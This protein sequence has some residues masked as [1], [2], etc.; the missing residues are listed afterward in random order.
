MRFLL[1]LLLL[2]SC[3]FSGALAQV[4][5]RTE[6]KDFPL[7]RRTMP[8][9]K[10][11][12]KLR[13]GGANLSYRPDQIPQLAIR[14]PGGKRSLG[15]WLSFLLAD[16]ELTYEQNAAGYLIYP[17]P[18][19][20]TRMI[21]LYGVVT[22]AETG[23]R[24]I[25]AS[26]QLPDELR[27]T[28]SN[29]Y[30]FYSLP[31]NGGRRTFRASYLGYE[32]QQME[33]LLRTDSTINF[34]LRPD[35]DLPAV[36]IRASSTE[37]GS[38]PLTDTRSSIGAEE[39]DRVGGPGG[40]TDPLRIA[41]LLPGV[42]SGAD[43]VGGLFIRG[44]ESG[45]NLVL[46]D[47]VPLYNLNHAAGLFSIFSNEAIKRVDLYRDGIPTRFG[48]RIGGVL[49]VHTRDG[50]LYEARTS[51]GTSML[52]AHLTSEGPIST[53]RSSYLLT[54]RYFWTGEVLRQLSETYKED[55]GRDGRIN[56]QVYDFN[57]K[58]NQQIGEKGRLYISLFR[59]V[60]DYANQATSTDTVEVRNPAG[61]EF[62]YAAPRRRYEDVRWANS[63][64][65]VRYNYVFNR[66]FFGNFRAHVSDLTVRAAYE[67][68]DS[69]NE[70]TSGI[71]SGD[72]FSGRY[73]SDI[74]Q[75]GIAFDGQYNRSNGDELRFGVE[76][77]RHSF[78]PQ[79]ASGRVPLSFHPRIASLEE[80]QT[81]TPI[82]TSGYVSLTGKVAGLSYRVGLRGQLWQ[83]MTNYFNVSP[84]LLVA[85][86]LGTRSTW[87]AAYDETV[88]SVHLVSSTVIGLPTDIWVPATAG[89]RPSRSRQV[90]FNYQY[91]LNKAWD[92]ESA[93]YYRDLSDLVFFSESSGESG[94]A[95]AL[96][97]GSGF[98]RGAEFTLSH[99]SPKLRGWFSYVL[100]Q[101]R[102][103]F[104]EEVNLGRAF[105]FRYGRTHAVKFVAMYS[106]SP[107]VSLAATWRFGSGANYSLSE[108]SF[109]LTNP[110]TLTTDGQAQTIALIKDLNGV[111][112]P[113]NHRLDLNAR[114]TLGDLDRSSKAEHTIS[115]GVY[116]LYSRHNPI[117]Y[118]IQT[119]YSSRDDQLIANRDFVQVYL[120]PITPTFS[121]RIRFGHAGIAR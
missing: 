14:V 8:I 74:T 12:I 84:R 68:S 31:T 108:E 71:N 2:L 42:E 22:D 16:T 59:G 58:L 78:T 46:L 39:V 23:E 90:S 48:G 25:G 51:T 62:R 67:R 9:E 15:A 70:V 1:P 11:L 118:D 120:A 29:E 57:L 121:Y 89:L 61:T 60:D 96:S 117:Y 63:V 110:A 109:L 95:N 104:D 77:N 32:A 99:S 73:G 101:S 107:R 49:D 20:P 24:L 79:L 83:N 10:A 94:W 7:P 19:L 5:A 82:E 28:V 100:S 21:N 17:D 72:I 38:G 55:L 53:G 97:T 27:G 36:I 115:L 102:R 75:V 50:H 44:S 47:G 6:Q 85:G 113:A 56:Y 65:A 92:I 34:S 105:D 81:M 40:E 93:V 114:F 54:G 13:A 41:R 43:G 69:L 111:R 37:T 88:Q 80:S 106:P 64:G 26:I 76:A 18:D 86:R 45:H 112:L 98:A 87:R 35:R 33:V 4:D 103:Q 91:Q 116:N 52:A 30:G 119:T 66:Q 3:S